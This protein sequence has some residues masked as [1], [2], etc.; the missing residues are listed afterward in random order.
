MPY[1]IRIKKPAAKNIAALPKEIKANVIN[2][3]FELAD[4]PRPA[5]CKKLKG[6]VNAWRIRVGDYRIIYS[7]F[8]DILI[9]EVLRV[10]HRKDAY[11]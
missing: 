8:D 5:D 9:I 6:K 7:I 10:N 4:N 2:H 1:E 3:I 11:K